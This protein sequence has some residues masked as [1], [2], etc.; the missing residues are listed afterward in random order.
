LKQIV[1]KISPVYGLSIHLRSTAVRSVSIKTNT[2]DAELAGRVPKRAK[3]RPT[4][5]MLE[6]LR[7][8]ELQTFQTV[9]T[10]CNS[11]LLDLLSLLD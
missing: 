9:E 3:Q 10:S 7:S 4:S 2:F 5:F 11:Q 6:A 8:Q 1:L